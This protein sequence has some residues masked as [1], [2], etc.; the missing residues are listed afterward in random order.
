MSAGGSARPTIP[1]LEGLFLTFRGEAALQKGDPATA[2]DLARQAF[3]AL[4]L[5]RFAARARALRASPA[6]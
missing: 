2:L 1:Q 5:E 6:P 4:G 3:D